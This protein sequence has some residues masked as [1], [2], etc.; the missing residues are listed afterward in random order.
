MLFDPPYV[1]H[2]LRVIAI[3]F[4]MRESK[5]RLILSIFVD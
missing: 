4:H 5:V 1:V 2:Q 3:S